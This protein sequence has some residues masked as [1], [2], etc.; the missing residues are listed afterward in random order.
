MDA[1]MIPVIFAIYGITMVVIWGGVPFGGFIGA[2]VLAM[3]VTLIVALT[4]F[5]NL[6]EPPDP[7]L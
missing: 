6:L 5:V 3:L 7:P 1:G 2:V 4:K